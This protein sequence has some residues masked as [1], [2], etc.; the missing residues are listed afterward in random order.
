MNKIRAALGGVVLA[1]FVGSVS[2]APAVAAPAE[3]V[4]AAGLSVLQETGP[5]PAQGPNPPDPN[6]AQV[7]D[8]PT[9]G[10]MPI[11]PSDDESVEAPADG[12][13]PSEVPVDGDASIAQPS[14]EPAAGVEPG[15]TGVEPAGGQGSDDSV[16]A[17]SGQARFSKLAEVTKP[18]NASRGEWFR[19]LGMYRTG[20]NYYRFDWSTDGCS[21]APERIPGGYDFTLPCHRHDFGYRNHKK[22]YGTAAFRSKHKNRIDSVFLEDMRGVCGV[23]VWKDWLT[24]AMRSKMRAACYKT[25]NKYYSAVQ[26]LG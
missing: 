3:G 5:I 12:S 2:V 25:A 9:W 26:A 7:V 1:A 18:G 20:S 14:E 4:P 6:D 19:L 15:G 21:S 23:K 22:I 11:E 16:V 24:P 8:D 17:V 13:P 10:A